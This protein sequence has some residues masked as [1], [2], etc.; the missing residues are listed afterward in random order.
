[1]SGR[2]IVVGSVNVDL[3]VRASHLPGPGE[4]VTGGTFE[5]HHGGKGGNQ[6]VAAAR[7]GRPTLFVGAVGDDAF[8]AEARAALQAQHVDVSRLLTIPGAATGVALILVDERAEN[9]IGVASG[10]NAALEPAMVAEALGRLGPLRGDVVLVCHEIPTAA[11][12]EA[13]RA[14]GIEARDCG[15]NALAVD[16]PPER[17]GEVAAADGI[18]LHE[19]RRQVVVRPKKEYSDRFP[20]EMPC[21]LTVHLKDGRVLEKEKRDYEG[22]VTRPMSWATAEAKFHALASPFA[23]E[24]LRKQI[25]RAVAD[26]E[27]LQAADLLKLLA[28]ISRRGGGRTS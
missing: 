6:A 26:L 9:L 20:N 2:V 7:L 14:A 21:H 27:N 24:G 23:A 15:E 4:T 25:T 8:G 12:R 22:F 16:A 10:A 17:I 5:R 3:V 18:V 19:L 11:V 1:M 28:K 13:L